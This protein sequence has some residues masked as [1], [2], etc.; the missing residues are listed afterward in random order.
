M[1]N[2]PTEEEMRKYYISKDKDYPIYNEPIKIQYNIIKKDITTIEKGIIVHQVNCQGVMGSGVALAI[3]NKFPLAYSEYA[4]SHALWLDNSKFLGTVQ[5]VEINPDLFVGNLYGQATYGYNG[6]R[7]TSYS[8]WEKA[9]PSLK[10]EIIARNI[11][12]L[13]IY[14]PYLVGADRGGG[15]FIILAEMIKEYFPKVTFC[16]L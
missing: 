9:L 7:F 4:M 10:K 13:P 8:A 15:N 2:G 6:G 3:K 5:L 11:E 14:F 16:K 1:H 12:H